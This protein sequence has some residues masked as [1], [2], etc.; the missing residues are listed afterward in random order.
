MRAKSS[1]N[2]AKKWFVEICTGNGCNEYLSVK[3]EDK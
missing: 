2:M 1:H 3:G